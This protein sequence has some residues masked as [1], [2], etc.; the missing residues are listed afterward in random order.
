MQLE[1]LGKTQDAN[2][3]CEKW[4]LQDLT[5]VCASRRILCN[6]VSPWNKDEELVRSGE[7]MLGVTL[8]KLSKLPLGCFILCKYF[9]SE[10]FKLLSC[11]F[12]PGEVYG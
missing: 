10:G 11:V 2:W 7:A 5:V 6:K 1:S 9:E 8:P 4:P 3:F 12:V